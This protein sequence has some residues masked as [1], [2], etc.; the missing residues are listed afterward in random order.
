MN[1]FFFSIFPFANVSITL[2][3]KEIMILF[4]II[5]TV[6]TVNIFSLLYDIVGNV[7]HINWNSYQDT[8][9]K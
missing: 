5:Y 2:V 3:F 8:S 7:L 4:P 1:I 6:N 9:H